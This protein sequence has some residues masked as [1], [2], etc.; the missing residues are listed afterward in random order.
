M[1]G[2]TFPTVGLGLN[3]RAEDYLSASVGNFEF[4]RH[5]PLVGHLVR[6]VAA[7]ASA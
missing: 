1:V 6:Q 7:R 4:Q 3:G 5:V 2:V